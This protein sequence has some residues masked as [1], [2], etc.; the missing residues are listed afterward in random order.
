MQMVSQAGGIDAFAQQNPDSIQEVGGLEAAK[1]LIGQAMQSSGA[2]TAIVTTPAK[3]RALMNM[4]SQLAQPYDVK[5]A[6]L[7]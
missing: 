3:A 1:M 5:A 2:K 7:I 4:N 6:F